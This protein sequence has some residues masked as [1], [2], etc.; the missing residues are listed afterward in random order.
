MEQELT[1]LRQQLRQQELVEA[2]Q[3]EPPA[4]APREI[5]PEAFKRMADAILDGD[6]EAGLKVFNE[7]MQPPAPVAQPEPQP[8]AKPEPQPQQLPPEIA[9]MVSVAKSFEAQYPELDWQGDNADLALIEDVKELRELNSHR[10]MSPAD[11]LRS[12]VNM[13]VQKNGLVDRTAAAGEE[14]I[15]Q[16]PSFN[17]NHA[18]ANQELIGQ[19][20]DL[21]DELQKR[22]YSNVDALRKAADLIA[23]DNG[24]KPLQ[25]ERRAIP[26][27]ET[28]RRM[29]P[30]T[31]ESAP[32]TT[33]ARNEKGQFVSEKPKDTSSKVA[34]A[35]QEKG[36]LAGDSGRTNTKLKIDEMTDEQFVNLSKEAMAE[37][38]GDTV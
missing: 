5:D 16:Y 27:A 8:Q 26:T 10:G 14:I 21:Q 22:G 32:K 2:R 20:L 12:A 6:T 34:A 24:I 28:P 33:P 23:Y 3:P 31:P 36:K 35:S 17:A 13:V 37:L 19:V 9:E 30:G 25:V 1:T 38:R 11:A 29:L 7:I 4:P 15:A 18:E